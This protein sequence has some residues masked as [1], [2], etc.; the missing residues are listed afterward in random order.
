V[1]KYLSEALVLE[2]TNDGWLALHAACARPREDQRGVV[3]FLAGGGPQDIVAAKTREGCLPLHLAV[4]SGAALEV[5]EYLAEKTGPAGLMERDNKGNLPLHEA[6]RSASLEVFQ[7]LA[8]KQ[9]DALTIHNRAGE[10]PLDL[11]RKWNRRSE[12]VAFLEKA[13]KEKEPPP[14]ASQPSFISCVICLE[15]GAT[16]AYFPCRHLCVCEA[17]AWD[18]AASGA[19]GETANDPNRHAAFGAPGRLCIDNADGC[20][21]ALSPGVRCPSCNRGAT[22]CVRMYF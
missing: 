14:R 19:S 12:M 4:Q 15:P 5:V 16:Y 8:E 9:P 6:A 21:L 22:S 3:Q 13:T 20:V 11:A 18:H 17:C 10:R 2:K 7:F 1:L